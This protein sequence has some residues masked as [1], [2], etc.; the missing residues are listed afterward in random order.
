MANSFQQP[1]ATEPGGATWHK[2]DD[3]TAGYI[4]TKT[5]WATADSFTAGLEIDFGIA[6]VKREGMKA[7]RCN[8][9]GAGTGDYPIYFYR[10]SGDTNISNTP[11]ASGESSH[12]LFRCNAD[13]ITSRQC[14]IWLSADYKAQ[15]TVRYTTQDI[16]ISYPIEYLL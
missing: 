7:V 1:I 4:G 9:R 5:T 16:Y 14:V 15:F 11:N 10:K 13:K 2:Y 12:E 8:I 6:G 3:P